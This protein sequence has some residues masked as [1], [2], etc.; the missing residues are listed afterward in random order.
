[1]RDFAKNNL[2]AFGFDEEVKKVEQGR[3]PI[4]GANVKL[5][6]FHDDK[7]RTEFEISGFCQA[8][9]NEVFSE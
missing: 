9:Q 4:C 8:C 6:D 3:C 5:E 2:R 7:S 1:M